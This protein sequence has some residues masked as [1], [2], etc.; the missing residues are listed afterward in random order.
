[1]FVP[2]SQLLQMEPR[3][4]ECSASSTPPLANT[5]ALLGTIFFNALISYTLSS[6]LEDQLCREL[7]K[8]HKHLQ[9]SFFALT[10]YLSKYYFI[11]ILYYVLIYW[12]GHIHVGLRTTFRVSSLLPRVGSGIKLRPSCLA[13]QAFDQAP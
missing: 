2:T 6:Y 3:S 4:Q 12:W 11:Q 10:Y 7:V 1:M 9:C 8:Y 5:P 13:T